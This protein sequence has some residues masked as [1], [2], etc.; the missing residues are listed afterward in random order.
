MKL[1]THT[2]NFTI[3]KMDGPYNSYYTTV[4]TTT[5]YDPEDISLHTMEKTTTR[6]QTR[7]K[8]DESSLFDYN[9]FAKIPASAS[10]SPL[11]QR[12]T[13]LRDRSP[14][15]TI[16]PRSPS[17]VHQ[18]TVPPKF[19]EVR[20]PSPKDKVEH[21]EHNCKYHSHHLDYKYT[22]PPV[23]GPCIACGQYIVGSV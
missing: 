22:P 16:D 14:S 2:R 18:L 13:Q 9:D 8:S 1:H 10:R 12:K 15:P 5:T 23:K 3:S 11:P 17:P 20:T 19:M 7:V 21:S 6:R 4:T